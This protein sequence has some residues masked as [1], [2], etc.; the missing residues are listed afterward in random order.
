M[1][2]LIVVLIIFTMLNYN[3]KGASDITRIGK[4]IKL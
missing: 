4:L 2:T 3:L 1:E